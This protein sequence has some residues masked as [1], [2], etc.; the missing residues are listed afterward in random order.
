MTLRA[1]ILGALCGLLIASLGY[2]NDSVLNLTRI[3]GNFFPVSVFGFLVILGVLV[4]PL[5]YRLRPSWRLGTGELGIIITLMLAACS[6]PGS[7]LMRTFPHSLA[8]PIRKMETNSATW[9]ESKILQYVPGTLLP[10]KPAL[11]DY[12]SANPKPGSWGDNFRRVPWASWTHPLENWIPILILAALAAIG[13]S[14][15]VHRQWASRERLR[16]PIADFASS[17]MAQEPDHGLGGVFRNKLFWIGLAVV[18]VIH[19][20]NG[21]Y[22][23]TLGLGA[24][25]DLFGSAHKIPLLGQIEIPMNVDL[26]PALQKKFPDLAQVGGMLFN[27]K[28]YFTVAAFGFLLASD[29]SLSLGLSQLL[30]TVMMYFVLMYGVDFR[31]DHMLNGPSNWMKFGSYL[32]IALL[33][34]YTGRRYYSQVIQKA[35]GLPGKD[36]QID[37]SAVWGFRLFL[38]ACAGLSALL[39]HYGVA[40]PMALGAVA[41]LMMLYLVMARLTAESG[42]FFIQPNWMPLGV[43]FGLFGAKAMGPESLVIIGLLCAV[44]AVDPRECLMPFIVNGLKISDNTGIKPS[45]VGWATSTVFILGLLAAT[46]VVLMAVYNFTQPLND[47]WASDIVPAMPFEPAMREI[48]KLAGDQTLQLSR[49]MGSWQRLLHMD[50]ANK[51]FAWTGLGLGLVLVVSFLRLR[52][53]WWPL[54]PILFLVWNSYPMSYFSSSFLLGWLIKSLTNRFGGT[55]GYRSVRIL[56]FGII[57]GDV[58]GGLFFMVHGFITFQLTGYPPKAQ[59]WLFP[60]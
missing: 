14:L 7:G 51:F 25:F 41:L 8:I 27:V 53:P 35:F 11:D 31:N 4:N 34:G 16:Y 30:S 44:L 18:F 54:H 2:M 60:G 37:S 56:M 42:L 5:L 43:L 46:P 28:L 50:P 40:W 1:I 3:V 29:L 23:V 47:R 22:T 12:L 36:T 24:G 45:R 48:S 20:F 39:V 59:Y 38:A 10:D 57:A 32:G 6:I 19:I 49:D 9:G 55:T 58:L 17:L 13:L 15:T 26:R 33:L 21:F 52:F